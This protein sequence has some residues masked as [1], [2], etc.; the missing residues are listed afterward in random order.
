MDDEAPLSETEAAAL[1]AFSEAAAT[2]RPPSVREVAR[3]TGAASSRT[4]FRRLAALEAKGYLARE[5][6]ARGLRL[7]EAGRVAA[8]AATSG[9]GRFVPLVGRVAAGTPIAT[10][11]NLDGAVEVDREALGARGP[12]FALRVVGDSMIGD[13]I[14]DGDIVLVREQPRVEEGEI[15]VVVIEEEATVKRVHAR[16]D[17]WELRPSNPRHAP[18]RVGFDEEATVAGKVVGVLR[19]RVR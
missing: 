19:S 5:A 15:A 10:A 2:G 12:V 1:A 11:A 7:T 16:P 9:R 13:H 18:I 4:A 14:L 6:G 17:G 8:A 3:R